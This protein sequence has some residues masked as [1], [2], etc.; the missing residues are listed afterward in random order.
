[1]I[2]TGLTHEDAFAFVQARRFCVAP[3]TE[4]VH[5]LEVHSPSP[6]LVSSRLTYH[7]SQAYRPIVLASQAVAA[8][9]GAQAG[10][11]ARRRGRDDDE[12]EGDANGDMTMDG[13]GAMCVSR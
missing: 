8:D 10:Q 3:R 4:F 7:A 6:A 5:Q 13:G 11:R 1:M 9:R 12:D 2:K